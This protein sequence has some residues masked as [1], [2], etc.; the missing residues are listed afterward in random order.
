MTNSKNFN[1]SIDQ[2]ENGVVDVRLSTSNDFHID[3]SFDDVVK[4]LESVFEN[5]N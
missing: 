4:K 5:L 1:I 3:A 2:D